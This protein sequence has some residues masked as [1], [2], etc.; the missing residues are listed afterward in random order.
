MMSSIYPP[1]LASV[2]QLH[3]LIVRRRRSASAQAI[4]ANYF[5][6]RERPVRMKGGKRDRRRKGSRRRGEE[7][8]KVEGD[9]LNRKCGWVSCSPVRPVVLMTAAW[10]MKVTTALF[11]LRPLSLTQPS[12]TTSTSAKLAS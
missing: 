8:M 12:Q 2:G 11:E 5:D 4:D 3:Q 1:L 9:R 7:S 10:D 6:A